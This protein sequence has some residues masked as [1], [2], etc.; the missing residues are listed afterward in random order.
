MIKKKLQYKK[1]DDYHPGMAGKLTVLGLD[2]WN[3]AAPLW[4]E[5]GGGIRA[6]I[7]REVKVTKDN[8]GELVMED[9]KSDINA[10]K[11]DDDA[12]L[13]DAMNFPKVLEFIKLTAERYE[14]E[15]SRISEILVNNLE[16]FVWR[17][18]DDI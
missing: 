1:V 11:I 3:L 10:I 17:E 9:L 16:E 7:Y 5:A 2:G 8:L 14:T 18:S 12:H 13:Y 6:L 15:Q 4:M